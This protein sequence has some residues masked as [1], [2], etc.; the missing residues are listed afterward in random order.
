MTGYTPDGGCCGRSDVEFDPVT[1]IPRHDPATM[2][3]NAPGVYIAGVLSAGYN[4]NKVFIENG[5]GHGELIVR[6]AAA[7]DRP[8]DRS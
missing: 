7:V 2:M 3:T 1:G 5:R 8:R 4:A 6:S